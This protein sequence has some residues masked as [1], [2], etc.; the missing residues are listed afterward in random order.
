MRCLLCASPV[1]GRMLTNARVNIFGEREARGFEDFS[2]QL[3]FARGRPLTS[4]LADGSV[5]NVFIRFAPVN[6]VDT[7]RE[8]RRI[9]SKGTRI[10][11]YGTSGQMY[12]RHAA[13]L[14][15]SL[16]DCSRVVMCRSYMSKYVARGYLVTILK[17]VRFA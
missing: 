11:F 10:C 12:D 15:N 16:A 1:L 14:I 9:S 8:I 4:K 5:H 7:L 2:T 17:L 6:T 13:A 3:F